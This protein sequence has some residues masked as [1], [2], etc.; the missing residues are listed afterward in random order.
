M[1]RDMGNSKKMKGAVKFIITIFGDKHIGMLLTNI[2]SILQS[3]P[4]SHVAVFWQDIEERLIKAIMKG[5]RSVTFI[6]T[7]F[8]L[9]S[10]PIKRISSKTLLWN[11]AA[12][13]YPCDNICILDVDTLVIRNIGHFFDQDFD[14]VF[15]YKD[16][17]FPLNTGVMLCKGNKYP[18]F[19]G[20]WEEETI[21]II[22]DPESFEKANSPEYPYG[23]PDQMSFFKLLRYNPRQREYVL[24]IH[25]QELIVK[26]MPCRILNEVHSREIRESTH[27]IHYKGGW[28]PILL[29]GQNFTK[30]RT[31]APSWEMYILYLKTFKKSMEYLHANTKMCYKPKDFNMI[32]PFYLN[33]STFAENKYLY[34]LYTNYNRFRGFIKRNQIFKKLKMTPGTNTQKDEVKTSLKQDKRTA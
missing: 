34:S 7:D 30:F 6:E 18:L 15:T 22:N 31:K 5:F 13:T 16:E 27:I 28:Q 21:K 26:A 25:G 1:W 32:I 29:K 2:Y 23:G 20:T 12:K 14:I 33:T 19:F 24:T 4:G 10:D 3:N 17:Q 9:T 8:D 11:Y